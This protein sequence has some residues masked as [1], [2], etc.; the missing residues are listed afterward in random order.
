[1]SS[2]PR[3]RSP[4]TPSCEASLWSRAAR[5][6]RPSGG[7]H[8]LARGPRV[9]TPP[10]A[11]RSMPE[12]APFRRQGFQ[13]AMCGPTSATHGPATYRRSNKRT[14]ASQTTSST[15][16]IPTWTTRPSCGR[17]PQRGPPGRG[18]IHPLR[19]PASLLISGCRHFAIREGAELWRGTESLHKTGRRLGHEFG[20][21][22]I[23]TDACEGQPPLMDPSEVVGK[24]PR[25]WGRSGGAG[26][27]SHLRSRPVSCHGLHMLPPRLV[28]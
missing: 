26:R 11:R 2:W 24:P 4:A 5:E 9:G 10:E 6:T 21:A 15:R 7:G 19:Q 13:R 25:W 23:T 28:K 17:R 27:G 1:M 3:S 12:P 8:S 16:W 14:T 18:V 20:D 22:L